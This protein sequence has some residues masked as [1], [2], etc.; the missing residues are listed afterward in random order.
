MAVRIDRSCRPT[1][2]FPMRGE[3]TMT[4]VWERP[5]A[6]QRPASAGNVLESR[7]TTT[8]PTSV[9][10]AR[11]VASGDGNDLLWWQRHG[12]LVTCSF[13][14]RDSSVDLLGVGADIAERLLQR[15][16]RDG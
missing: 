3:S 10:A 8:R 9:A 11:I 15:S 13:D 7:V 1:S 16:A 14:V 4:P 5:A 12:E 2:R 6:V